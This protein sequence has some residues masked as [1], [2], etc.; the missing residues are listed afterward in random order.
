MSA[1]CPLLHSDLGAKRHQRK[2]HPTIMAYGSPPL[3][4]KI[5]GNGNSLRSNN[6]HLISYFIPL[7]SIVMV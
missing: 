2:R 5:S 6:H 1:K 3:L 7:L 4:N